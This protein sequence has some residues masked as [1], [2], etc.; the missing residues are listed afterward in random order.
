MLELLPRLPLYVA[1][2]RFRR[3]R[4]LPL[5]LVVSVTY[6]CNSRCLTCNIWRKEA[7]EL[8]LEEWRKVLAKIGTAPYYLTFSGGEP[9]LREDIVELVAAAYEECH[10]AIITIPTNGLAWKVIPEKVER[11]VKAAP[12]AQ[13]GINLSLDEIGPRHDAIRGV[14]GGYERAL[15]TYKE[16]RALRYPNLTLTI[17]TVISRY[18][19][20]RLTTV[21]GELK[22]LGADI[23]ISEIA[24]EREELGTMGSDIAPPLE[25]YNK[26][27]DYLI[28]EARNSRAPGLAKITQ[29]FRAHYYELTKRILAEKRQVIPCYAGFASGHIAPN[30]DVWTCCTRAQSVGNLQDTDYEFAPLWFG[31]EAERLRRSIAAGECYCPMANASYTNMLLHTPTLLQV[32]K[33]LL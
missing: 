31:E 27:A 22:T 9:F 7:P 12:Q 33:S 19:V 21:R 14:A 20:E 25:E 5:S 13:V 3:P 11:I 8:T 15:R 26:V 17:H 32:A 30:G 6:R 1:F 2:R 28:A 4:L 18:N 23:Y 10:P 29:A 24:E 16:L